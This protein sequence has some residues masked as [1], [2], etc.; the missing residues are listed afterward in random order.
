[1][2]FPVS[3][4]LSAW[5]VSGLEGSALSTVPGLPHLLMGFSGLSAPQQWWGASTKA[6][7]PD[8]PVPTQT[9][10]PFGLQFSVFC[11]YIQDPPGPL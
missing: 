5:S 3:L 4:L 6:Q 7:T 9:G 1:M 10:Q 2:W 11:T 8:R